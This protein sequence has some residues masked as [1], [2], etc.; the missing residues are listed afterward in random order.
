M[1]EVLEGIRLSGY[2]KLFGAT[3]WY[4][5][6][7]KGTGQKW[8][9][10][11]SCGT[12][13]VPIPEMSAARYCPSFTLTASNG[14]LLAEGQ[15][16]NITPSDGAEESVYVISLHAGAPPYRWDGASF[17]AWDAAAMVASGVH[18]A[19]YGAAQK[20][21]F[22]SL[23]PR[24]ER[25]VRQAFDAAYGRLLREHG[26]V[27]G[28]WARF[29]SV[30]GWAQGGFLKIF[31]GWAWRRREG[32]RFWERVTGQRSRPAEPR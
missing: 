6:A 29:K 14:T 2:R 10:T 7:L 23:S 32:I 11:P 25:R 27:T 20:L 24:D 28:R 16:W 3:H 31:G 21:L 17:I 22:S 12:I 19:P 13:H 18:D 26:K 30:R 4:R 9:L 8:E 15:W 5:P 1:K